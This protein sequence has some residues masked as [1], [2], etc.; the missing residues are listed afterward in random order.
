MAHSQVEQCF[1][2]TFRFNPRRGGSE[3]YIR[4]QTGVVF[5]KL[6]EL[7]QEVEMLRR[8]ADRMAGRYAA[9]TDISFG[10]ASRDLALIEE[11][12]RSITKAQQLFEAA[13]EAAG[14]CQFSVSSKLEDYLPSEQTRPPQE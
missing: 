10:E 13:V 8:E 7:A 3:Q 1:Q 4:V 9:S 12:D 6:R 14:G 5:A 11:V 2:D